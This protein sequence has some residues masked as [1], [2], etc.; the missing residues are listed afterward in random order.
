MEIETQFL[1]VYP[2]NSNLRNI[3]GYQNRCMRFLK[4]SGI[5]PMAVSLLCDKNIN[6]VKS[7]QHSLRAYS[8]F[9][10]EFLKRI[11]EAMPLDN[12]VDFVDE[13]VSAM[14][15]TKDSSDPF[16]DSDMIGNGAH[17]DIVYLVE[18]EGIKVFALSQTF[19]LTELSRRA[20]YVYRN[21]EQLIHGT[22]YV[23]DGTFGFV[24]LSLTLTEGDQIVIR[25]Y[26]S[27]AFN[28]IPSTPTK[29]GL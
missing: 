15:I 6:I 21:G 1:G 20:V 26:S 25:E 19:N 10:N 27:T 11:A 5:A 13:V 14:T 24:R 16:A 9:K 18:D 22:D 2:G 8:N 3:D 29:L 17:S 7:I 23:F 12:V 28:Y 4:H